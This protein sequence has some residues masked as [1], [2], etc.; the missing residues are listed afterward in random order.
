MQTDLNLMLRTEKGKKSIVRNLRKDG[1]VPC[2]CYGALKDSV[3]VYVS[4]KDLKQALST[5]AKEHVLLNLKTDKKSDVNN[6]VAILK[7]ID[8]HPVKRT[9]VHADFLILDMSKPI[10]VSA[11][12]RLVGKAKGLT[13]GGILDQVRRVV[14]IKCL[15]DSIPSHLDVDITELDLNESLHV[16]D[17][18]V[19]EGVEILTSGKLTIA[20]LAA[21][22]V[23]VEE[24]EGEEIEGE[25]GEET[26]ETEKSTEE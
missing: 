12:V 1:Y 24:E 3:S 21:P 10:K 15:P 8:R 25:E 26:E 18:P 6:K 5:D 9:Y 14:D 20:N 11:D 16:S 17:I 23:E 22:A 4:A 13:V 7:S 19:P 2:V